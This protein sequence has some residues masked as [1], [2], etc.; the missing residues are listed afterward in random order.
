MYESEKMFFFDRKTSGTFISDLFSIL[1]IEN[2][3]K[4]ET[5]KMA[6]NQILSV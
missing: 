5:L 4:R 3:I 6:P 1:H 2:V